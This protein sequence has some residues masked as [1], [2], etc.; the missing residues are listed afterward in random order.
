MKECA[1][2]HSERE[3]Q[4][5]RDPLLIAASGPQFVVFDLERFD[6][7]TLA[8][9][10]GREGRVRFTQPHGLGSKLFEFRAQRP[11]LRFQLLQSQ[12]G[13]RLRFEISGRDPTCFAVCCPDAG[14]ALPSTEDPQLVTRLDST[15]NLELRTRAGAQIQSD[16]AAYPADV[17]GGRWMR[18]GGGEKKDEGQRKTEASR[19]NAD[20]T[21]KKLPNKKG[22]AL[23]AR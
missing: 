21:Q 15:E 9:I 6:L 10:H 16:I 14:P 11:S 1:D 3:N 8:A 20:G 17:C 2:E 4:R 18:R 7:L 13:R 12:R 19:T 22:L 5:T 23:D